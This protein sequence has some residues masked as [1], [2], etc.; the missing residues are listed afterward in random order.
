MCGRVQLFEQEVY[1]KLGCK[2]VQEPLLY[3]YREV[4]PAALIHAMTGTDKLV[5]RYHG[6]YGTYLRYGMVP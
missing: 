4:G 6:T 1:P 2:C 5:P 3:C